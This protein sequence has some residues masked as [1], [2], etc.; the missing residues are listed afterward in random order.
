MVEQRTATE[1]GDS[2][3]RKPVAVLLDVMPERSQQAIVDQ[4]G[5]RFEVAFAR[6]ADRADLKGLVRNATVLLAMWGAVDESLIEA[7]AEARVIQK[8]GVGTD[9]ID[10]GAAERCGIPV[11]KAAGINADAVAETTILL[12][13]AVSRH[14]LRAVRESR[15]GHFEKE[16]LRAETFQL[17][18]KTFGLFGLG[19]IGQAVARRLTGFGVE[20]LYHDVVRASSDVENAAQATY[21]SFE[22]LLRRSDIVSLHVPS[23]PQTV[24]LFNAETFSTMKEGAILINTARGALVDETALAQAVRDGQILGAGLDVT[25]QEPLPSTSPLFDLDRV[26]VTPH[27]AGAVGNNFPRVVKRAYDNATALLSGQAVRPDDIVVWPKAMRP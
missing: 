12:T 21:V 24:G 23:T 19:H 15:A 4:F 2:V 3:L 1:T 17:T 14:L 13:L 20:I 8:L 16:A 7:A 18:G 25:I 9:K 27:I 6:S 5:D 10:V 11:L 22:E 26:V